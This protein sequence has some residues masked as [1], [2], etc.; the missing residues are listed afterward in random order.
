MVRSTSAESR[1]Q[2]VE[3]RTP[4]NVAGRRDN[5]E[6]V[7]PPNQTCLHQWSGRHDGSDPLGSIAVHNS[8]RAR[9]MCVSQS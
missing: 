8:V 3:R 5:N 4:R 1:D 2:L 7:D 6:S 9:R